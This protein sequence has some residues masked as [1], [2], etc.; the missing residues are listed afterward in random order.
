MLYYACRLLFLSAAWC[1]A[2]SAQQVLV[3]I[4]KEIL[5]CFILVKPINRCSKWLPCELGQLAMTLFNTK[6]FS[7]ILWWQRKIIGKAWIE[8]WLECTNIQTQA[9]TQSLRVREGSSPVQ[10]CTEEVVVL[11]ASEYTETCSSYFQPSDDA[12]TNLQH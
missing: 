1:W 6:T 8:H 2:G 12:S 9:C 4:S 7:I 5:I 11:M 10:N 3:G